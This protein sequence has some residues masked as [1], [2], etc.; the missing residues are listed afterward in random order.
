M[1]HRI[2]VGILGFA[3]G[4]VNAYCGQWRDRKELGVDVI[5]G[6][7]HDAVRLE[8]AGNA[9][10]VRGYQDVE[11][12][13]ADAG[14][15]AVVVSAE[16]AL[17]ADLVEKAA[18]AGKTIILQK[19]MALTIPEADRIVQAVKTSGVPFTMAWQMRVD[20]QN[21]QIK[22]IMSSGMLGQIFEVRRRHGLPTHIWPN[23]TELWHVN[24]EMNRDIWADDA[25]HPIDFIYWLLGAPETVTAEVDSLYDSRVPM[26]N[27]IAI[28][29]YPGGPIAVV[30][31]SFTCV[32]AENVTEVIAEKG[33]IVQ[34][35]GDVPS[36]NV[37]RPADACGLKWYTSE[38]GDW[39]CSDIASPPGHGARISGLAEP[40]AM[41]LH[42]ERAPVA[43]AEEGRVVLRM[44]LA[45]YVSAREG[46]RVRLEDPA[47]DQV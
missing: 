11:V 21:I 47:I 12:L 9:F 24:P 27:G 23:F 42:K 35:F 41:F 31:C 45:T 29:R 8:Q 46:R 17:H 30:N 36:C 34:N 4:H 28:F 20:P 6:W 19:P 2:K 40:L 33:S 39:V 37:P 1:A 7:D 18:A 26:D 22:E 25:A 13:L 44:T 10:G 3:H 14:V 32:A 16:T 15:S 43:T 38:K 5:A